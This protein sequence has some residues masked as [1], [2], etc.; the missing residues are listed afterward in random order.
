MFV[1]YARGLEM[2]Y[3][4]KTFM[5]LCLL[6]Y[7]GG[8]V[9]WIIYLIAAALMAVFPYALAAVLGSLAIMAIIAWR[10]SHGH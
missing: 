6:L 4:I 5:L 1:F 8:A 10:R 7:I 9:V 3:Y 2:D